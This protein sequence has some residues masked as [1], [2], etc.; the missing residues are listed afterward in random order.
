MDFCDNNSISAISA[1]FFPSASM[2][3][4]SNSRGDILASGFWWMS[5]WLSAID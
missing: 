4:M 1:Q 2:W 5:S 3:K